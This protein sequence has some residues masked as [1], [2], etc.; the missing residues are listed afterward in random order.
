MAGILGLINLPLIALFTTIRI[1]EKDNLYTIIS[2]TIF[3][4]GHTGC[5]ASFISLGAGVLA[6]VLFFLVIR[7]NLIRVP[8]LSSNYLRP[9][10]AR[11]KDRPFDRRPVPDG[12]RNR[13]STGDDPSVLVLPRG[14]TL[15]FLGAC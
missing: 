4:V 2:G 11:P 13:C 9:L 8:N 14:L 3:D 12:S 15:P 10:P 6:W 5:M 7:G 1:T